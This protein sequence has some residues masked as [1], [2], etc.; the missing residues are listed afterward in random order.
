MKTK[1][2]PSP[3]VEKAMLTPSLAWAYW[4][5]GSMA[6]TIL[7]HSEVPSVRWQEVTLAR[8]RLSAKAA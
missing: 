6:G 7:R 8:F 4:M 3:S 2:I 1:G 5:R